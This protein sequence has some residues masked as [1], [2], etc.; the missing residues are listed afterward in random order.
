[1][2]IGIGYTSRANVCD[3]IL[4]GSSRS[5]HHS[6]V[7]TS[8]VEPRGNFTTD[9]ASHSQ[10]SNGRPLLSV[11]HSALV[12]QDHISYPPPLLLQYLLTSDK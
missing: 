3:A 10:G 12:F 1:M 7:L 4:P 6:L 8:T 5:F 11:K 2:S 9:L